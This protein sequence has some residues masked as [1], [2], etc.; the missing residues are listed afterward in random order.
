MLILF[1][2]DWKQFSIADVVVEG[3]NYLEQLTHTLGVSE[4]VIFNCASLGA[5]EW[6]LGNKK[7]KETGLS[8]HPE[9]E[10][11][12]LN[13]L[14]WHHFQVNKA[15]KQS[16]PYVANRDMTEMLKLLKS[17]GHELAV[18]GAT[19]TD[20]ID[21]ALKETRARHYFDT[22]IFGYDRCADGIRGN[23]TMAALYATAIVERDVSYEDTLVVSDDPEAIHDAV[24]LEPRAVVGY[25][26]PY[27]PWAEQTIRLKEM[28][29]AG[30]DYAL[31]GAHSVSALPFWLSESALQLAKEELDN[32]RH[33]GLGT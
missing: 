24:P 8:R 28:S 4:R 16:R 10:K 17:A 1:N 3:N 15:L 32:I 2:L 12:T 11:D 33:L 19:R 31:V 25:L 6:V 13:Y 29:E 14:R 18:V 21:S 5:G 9:I 7:D 30:A 23:F 20:N 22:N 27:V 26:D